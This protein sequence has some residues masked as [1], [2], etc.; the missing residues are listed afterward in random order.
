MSL[1]KHLCYYTISPCEK[2]QFFCAES[3]KLCVICSRAS[4][5]RLTEQKNAAFDDH[6]KYE[7]S[8]AGRV[9]ELSGGAEEEHKKQTDKRSADRYDRIE[10]GDELE[11]LALAYD[12]RKRAETVAREN[13]GNTARRLVLC[14]PDKALR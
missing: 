12:L 1:I 8:A 5:Y 11:I 10:L 7:R 6:H 14:L 4:S 3:K 2:Q 13:G 9:S